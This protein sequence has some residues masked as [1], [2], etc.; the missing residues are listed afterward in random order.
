[1]LLGFIYDRLIV[2]HDLFFSFRVFFLLSLHLS[3]HQTK[4][5][6][7]KCMSIPA[8]LSTSE[9]AYCRDLQRL[10]GQ[11]AGPGSA[12][13]RDHEVPTSLSLPSLSLSHILLRAPCRQRACHMHACSLVSLNPAIDL[14]LHSC[15]VCLFFSRSFSREEKR[16]CM[17]LRSTGHKE[18]KTEEKSKQGPGSV[19]ERFLPFIH[20]AQLSGCPPLGLASCRKNHGGK[21]RSVIPLLPLSVCAHPLVAQR[22]RL[23]FH[24]FRETTGLSSRGRA[25]G[26]AA[27][28]EAE[29]PPSRGDAPL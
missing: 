24:S 7:T 22:D 3:D 18:T 15:D 12:D 28:E 9:A 16:V 2:S 23:L 11:T 17:E 25:P 1:M 29:A 5:R 27:D 26:L 13:G 4:Q 14:S 6:V 8:S 20:A 21:S 19:N 10:S